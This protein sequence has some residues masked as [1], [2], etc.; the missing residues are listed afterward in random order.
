MYRFRKADSDD[1]NA[2]VALIESAYRGNA[3]RQGWTTE[4]D[5]LDGQRTDAEEV[6]DLLAKP[7]SYFLLY[8]SAGVLLASVYLENRG[9]QGYLGM[10]AV[11]PK[12]QGQGIGKR[13]LDEAEK[14]IFDQWQCRSLQMTVISLREELIHWYQ[15]RGYTTTGD[16]H[17]FPYGNPRFGLPKRDDLKFVVLEKPAAN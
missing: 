14:I 17:A 4:A 15:R 8:E 9:R 2:I 3:S 10:F 12:Q 7:A 5:I 11:S 6:S 13:V 16:T 1:V